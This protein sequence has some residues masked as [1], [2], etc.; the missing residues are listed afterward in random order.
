[1]AL[2][3]DGQGGIQGE[4]V[5]L[6]NGTATQK[7]VDAV[8]ATIKSDPKVR[9]DMIRDEGRQG[10]LQPSAKAM[11]EGRNPQWRLSNDRTAELQ[12]LTEA[13]ERM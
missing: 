1:M 4:A 3:P 10:G 6:R 5:R 2:R 11:K 12:A 8:V 9:A 13:M 7:Q